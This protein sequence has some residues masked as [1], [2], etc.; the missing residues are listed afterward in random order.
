MELYTIFFYTL[1]AIKHYRNF[2]NCFM[3][4]KIQALVKS[5][6]F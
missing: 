6:K 1:M 4:N 3:E 2:L 5:I